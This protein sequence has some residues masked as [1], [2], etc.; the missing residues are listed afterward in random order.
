MA[1]LE[2]GALPYA[3][4]LIDNHFSHY[5]RYDGTINYRALEIPQQA[6]MLT[7]LALYQTY[8][9][10][11]NALMLKHYA[12]AKAIADLLVA[13]HSASLQYGEGDPRYGAWLGGQLFDVAD[14]KGVVVPGAE[15]SVS[16]IAS[17]RYI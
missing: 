2:V 1:A 9:G 11:D 12:K 6:R 7:I 5:V 3:R 10:G 13:R 4:G 17:M 16:M 14:N 8:S 15:M